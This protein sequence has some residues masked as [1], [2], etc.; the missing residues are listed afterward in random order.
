MYTQD[1]EITKTRRMSKQLKRTEK[2]KAEQRKHRRKSLCYGATSREQNLTVQINL[3]SLH[4]RE[5][6]K[7]WRESGQEGQGEKDGKE[8]RETEGRGRNI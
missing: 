4:C 7:E 5:R 8:V 1:H 6:A 3:E 2:K